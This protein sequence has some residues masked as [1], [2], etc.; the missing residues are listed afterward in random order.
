M[1]NIL[2]LL[3]HRYPFLLVD[4]IKCFSGNDQIQTIKNITLND[5]FLQ[6]HFPD[7]FIF[8]GVLM[9]ESIAQSAI[10]LALKKYP[11]Y[12]SSKGFYI[13][14]GINSVKFKKIVIPG[15]QLIIKVNIIKKYRDI[16]FFQGIICVKDHVVCYA[17]ISCKYVLNFF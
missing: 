7:V 17:K 12:R 14:S 3:P 10:I 5:P 16:I 4:R 11:E 6:G 2:K 13:L 15:D 1:E 9:L 8:P